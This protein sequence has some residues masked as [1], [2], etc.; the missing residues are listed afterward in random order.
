MGLRHRTLPIEGVQFHPE[1]VLT[2]GGHQMIRNFLEMWTRCLSLCD[3]NCASR[4]RKRQLCLPTLKGHGFSR[5]VKRLEGEAALAAEGTQFGKCSFPQGLKPANFI[6]LVLT[7][8]L[9]PCP[10]SKPGFFNEFF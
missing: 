9:K 10:Y 7:A 3:S 6:W 5:A 2:E 1:S 4:I 8:R